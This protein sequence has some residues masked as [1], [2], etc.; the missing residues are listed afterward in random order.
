MSAARLARDGAVAA[1]RWR[2]LERRGG[3]AAAPRRVRATMA[4]LP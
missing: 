3:V 2:Q 4:V 1:A